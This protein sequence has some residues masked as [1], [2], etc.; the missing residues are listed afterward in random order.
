M[1]YAVALWSGQPHLQRRLSCECALQPLLQIQGLGPQ[2]LQFTA[3]IGEE[4]T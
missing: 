3:G 4:R 2:V 1:V